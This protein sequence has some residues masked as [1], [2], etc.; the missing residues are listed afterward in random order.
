MENF[1]SDFYASFIDVLREHIP[2][3][4]NLCRFLTEIL[5]IERISVYRRLRGDVPFTLSEII[6]ITRKLNISLDALAGVTQPYRSLAYSMYNQDFFNLQETD[7][8]Q[9]ND[10]VLAIET[11][12]SMPTSEYGCASNCLPLHTMALY[13]P[14]YRFFVLK[15]MYQFGRSLPSKTY[16]E[17]QLPKRLL[18]THRKYAEAIQKIK[19]TFIIYHEYSFAN[20]VH[21][22]LFFKDIQLVTEKDVKL[23]KECLETSLATINRLMIDGHFKNGNRVEFYVSALKFETSYSFL[24]ANK[25]NVT[26]V[27]AFTLGALAS[28]D[29]MSMDMMRQWMYSMKRTSTILS[30]NEKNRIH[31]IEQQK[32]IIAKL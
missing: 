27:D 14:L 8:R 16:Q 20:F 9:S 5:H 23:I 10:Y 15:W 6:Q 30:R 4:G 2:R 7:Y 13:E 25:I 18:E 1:K 24:Y 29:P 32:K 11:A 3:R 21:D 22:V 19:D 26:M 31:F 12:A 17:I 28:V